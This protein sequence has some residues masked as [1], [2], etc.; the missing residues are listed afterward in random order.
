[1]V[2]ETIIWDL[3]L[4]VEKREMFGKLEKSLVS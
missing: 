2:L 3:F 1:M 4:L